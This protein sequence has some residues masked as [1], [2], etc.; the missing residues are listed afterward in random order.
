MMPGAVF[1][2]VYWV[3]MVRWLAALG[4]KRVWFLYT[5]TILGIVS[6]TGLVF[7]TVV[8]GYIGDDYRVIRRTGVS[9][10]FG[11]G[12]LAQLMVTGRLYYLRGAFPPWI[13][14]LK[15]LVCAGI[16]VWGLLNIFLSAFYENFDDVQDLIEWNIAILNNAYYLLTCFLWRTTVFT[17]DFKVTHASKDQFT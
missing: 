15:L 10:Y 11:L 7:Y 17:A 3:L 8:L 12:Y 2:A 5:I 14:N 4:E 9:L 16:L 13:F 6:A 1:M